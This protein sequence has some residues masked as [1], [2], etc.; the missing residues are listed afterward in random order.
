MHQVRDPGLPPRL[1]QRC[2]RQVLSKLSEW[3]PASGWEHWLSGKSAAWTEI[4]V[5]DSLFLARVGV[6]LVFPPMSSL[7]CP[8]R[9]VMGLV[10]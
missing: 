1:F 10:T 4:P 6:M 7:L 3:V 5:F 2:L 9:E 8:E